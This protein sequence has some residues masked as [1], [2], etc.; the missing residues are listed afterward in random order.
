MCS[1]KV[2]EWRSL[3]ITQYT[4]LLVITLMRCPSKLFVF[5]FR[6]NI[7]KILSLEDNTL[8][9]RFFVRISNSTKYL[10]RQKYF[11]G[12][13]IPTDTLCDAWPPWL[14]LLPLPF[15]TKCEIFTNKLSFLLHRQENIWRKDCSI[16]HQHN[17]LFSEK[18]FFLNRHVYFVHTAFCVVHSL[19]AQY[20]ICEK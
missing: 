9:F 17:I 2:A 10:F 14:F 19:K 5:V 18:L 13:P 11:R 1:K 12:N 16:F 6:E 3:L 20:S 8:K 4:R 7:K 15:Q